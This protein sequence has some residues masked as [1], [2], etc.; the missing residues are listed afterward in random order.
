MWRFCS[1]LSIAIGL[2]V[3]TF[4]SFSAQ[5]IYGLQQARQFRSNLSSNFYIQIGSYT[6]K[7]NASRVKSQLQHESNH[8]ALIKKVNGYYVVLIGPFH[9]AVE[10]RAAAQ[11][12]SGKSASVRVHHKTKKSQY[13][14]L[15]SKIPITPNA[16][17]DKPIQ[18]APPTIIYKGKHPANHWFI[19]LGGGWMAPFGTNT[20]NF[21]SSGM[22]GFPDDKYVTNNRNGTGQISAFSGYQWRRDTLW[23]PATSLSFE[24]TYSFPFRVNGFIFVNNLPDAKNFTF[25]YDV[26]QHV[27]MA[28]LKLD[29][30][31]W[32]QFMPYVSGGL[33]VAINQVNNYSDSPIPGAT[34]M[35]RRF[36]FTSASTTHFAGSFGAGLDYMFNYNSQITLGYELA[37]YGEAR[38]GYGKG[39]LNNDRLESKINSN[40]VILKG[41][42][43]FN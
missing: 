30:Y 43:F 25:K 36:G 35:H 31:Q 40:A 34:M 32:Q 26:L 13:R 16:N 15:G 42:Y 11:E 5:K 12:F 33:G 41:T 21:A 9:S 27:P 38:T 39:V 8:P 6:Y 10:L 19:G 4:P 24:Y 14:V 37:Y 18:K 28:K 3:I 29:L 17:T 2:S 22:P 7:S 20:T 23:F 1:K